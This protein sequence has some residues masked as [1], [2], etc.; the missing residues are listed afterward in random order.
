MSKKSF[1]DEHEILQRSIAS[2]SAVTD[3]KFKCRVSLFKLAG[4][5][6]KLLSVVG[7]NMREDGEEK[8]AKVLSVD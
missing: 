6:S 4:N 1:N 8:H 7:A 5:D 2:T 3:Y